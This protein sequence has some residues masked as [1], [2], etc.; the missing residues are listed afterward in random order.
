MRHNKVTIQEVAKEAKVSIATVSRVLNNYPHVSKRVKARVQ[1]AIKK[2][3]YQPSVFAQR[4]AGKFLNTVSLIMPAYEGMFYSYYGNEI[5][6]SVADACVDFDYDLLLHIS[7][8]RK[9]IHFSSVDGALFADIIENEKELEECVLQGKPCVVINRIVDSH[10]VSFV[11]VDN[12]GGAYEA[13][14][15][16]V[17]LGHSRIAHITGDLRTQCAQQRLEGYKKALE[18]SGIKVDEAFI[19]TG[20]FSRASARRAMEEFLRVKRH[21]TAVFCASDDMAQEAILVVQEKKLK[22]PDNISIIG[23]DDNPSCLLGPISLSTVRQPLRE[24]ARKGVEI[25][26]SHIKGKKSPEKVILPCRLVVRDSCD[27]A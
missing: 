19:K 2:L 24:M 1:E 4:L 22:V 26:D 11:A 21:P 16:F 15:Y 27:F 3:N 17:N 8:R 14:K 9:K 7:S 13:T 20:D 18:D 6:R 12:K 10:Q 25:L 23:F 5:V